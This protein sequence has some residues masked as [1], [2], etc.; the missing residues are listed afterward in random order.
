MELYLIRHPKP[1]IASG[2][3]YGQTDLALLDSPQPDA[4]RLKRQL[5]KDFL[6][7]SSPL[8]RA[9]LLAEALGQPRIDDRLMEINF[10]AWEML[11]F[12]DIGA[13]INAW[14]QDP[15]HFRMPQGESL[16][17]VAGRVN[18]WFDEQRVLFAEKPVVVVAHGGS[19]RVLAGRLLGIPSSRWLSLDFDYARLCRIDSHEWGYMLKGF[20]L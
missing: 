20:N 13:G 2:I 1:D 8:Q 15:M 18:Q 6:L 16:E 3:C 11:E 10:G 17:D 5:P 7:Y 12:S 14:V 9:R 4:R 19:L